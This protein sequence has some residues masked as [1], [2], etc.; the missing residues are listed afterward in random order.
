M[1]TRAGVRRI[2]VAMSGGVDSSVAAAM[3]VEAGHE[4]VGATMK[5]FCYSDEEVAR[6]TKTCCGLDGIQD[7]RAVA[8]RLGIRH[9]VFDVEREFTRDVIDDFVSEYSRGRTPNPCVRC[10]SNTKFRDL[11]RRG[12]VLGCDGVAS[13]HYVRIDRSGGETALLRG[14][15]GNKDQ[16]YF[17]WG[18]PADM[19]DRLYFPLGR[20]TKP[21]VRDR[22]RALGLVTADKPESQEICFVPTGDYRDFLARKLLPVHPALSPG[23]IVDHR[24]RIL[25]RHDGFSGFTVGQRKGLGG[26][27]PEP[28]YV[29]EI[30]PGTREVVVGPRH[31]LDVDGVVV[32]ARNV[33]VD[34]PQPRGR[35]PAESANSR[36]CPCCSSVRVSGTSTRTSTYWSPRRPSRL[37]PCPRIRKRVPGCVPGGMRST[38]F[39]PEIVLTRIFDPSVAWTRLIGTVTW[40]SFPSRRKKRCGV[41]LKVMTR[42]PGGPPFVPRSPCPDN[43]TLEPVSTPAGTETWMLRSWWIFPSPPHAPHSVSGLSPR[44]THAGHG[45]LTANPPWP[46]ETVPAPPHSSHFFHVVPGAPP[47][48]PHVAHSSFMGTAIGTLPP[49]AA[50]RNGTSTV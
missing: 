48:P 34:R 43:L 14:V 35:R 27:L 37:I 25:G 41:T 1:N 46:K 20:L 19:L 23:A 17:L 24:G 21:Q 2:L 16:S 4:V 49:L 50:T 18:L 11:L 22:A 28:Y 7:A 42:S 6:S 39:L 32:G 29:L 3:L 47:D 45:R 26:G 38:T 13:G 8:D 40:T 44:P 30:R 15:D 9:Y 33:L 36:I 31:L 10:N 5:T 12:R